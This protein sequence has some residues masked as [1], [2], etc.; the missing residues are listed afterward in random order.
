M[1]AKVC[2]YFKKRY[3][4]VDVVISDEDFDRLVQASD[5]DGRRFYSLLELSAVGGKFVGDDLHLGP[6]CLHLGRIARD[7]RAQLN[8]GSTGEQLGMQRLACIAVTDQSCVDIFEHHF[9][10]GDW[11]WAGGRSGWARQG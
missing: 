10:H 1:F 5:G 6:V 9:L 4:A 11:D 3:N 8:A 7:Y 2:V